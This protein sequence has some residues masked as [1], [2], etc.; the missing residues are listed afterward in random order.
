MPT[1]RIQVVWSHP[2]STS[3]TAAIA[4]DVITALRD[5][6]ATVDE[7]DL[8]RTDFDPRLLPV[9]E[10]DWEDPDHRYSDEVMAH[11]SRSRSADAVVFV[12]PVW[13]YSLPA[14]LKGYIDRVWNHGLFYGAGRRAGIPAVRW[15]GVAGESEESFAKRGYD[16]MMARHLNVGIAGL[17]GIQDSRLELLYDALGEDIDDLDAHFTA[18]RRRAVSAALEVLPTQG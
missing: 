17:C 18:L 5:A 7:L 4:A 9:D 1:S 15:L 10:P 6:G 8:A 13:W 12:F 3:L 14:H 11:A 16:E 2:R